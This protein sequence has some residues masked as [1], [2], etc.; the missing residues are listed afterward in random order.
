MS[1]TNNPFTTSPSGPALVP[2]SVHDWKGT[3]GFSY[4]EMMRSRTG[5]GT[6]AYSQQERFLVSLIQAEQRRLGR[7]LEVLEFG[8]GFGHHASYLAGLE[9]VRYHGYDMSEAMV[10]PL[11]QSPPVG[12]RPL[13]ERL[14][15]G[16]SPLSV[17]GSRRFDLVFTASVLIHNPIEAIPGLLDTLGQLTRPEGLVCLVENPLVPFGVWEDTWQQGCWLHAY[18]DAMPHGWD[19]HHG[20]GFT[21]THD[22]YVLKRN[23]GEQ[24]RYFEL[25]GPEQARDE[26]QPLTLEAL[27]ARAMPRLKAWANRAAHAL[28]HAAI[29]DGGR[30]QELQERMQVESERYQRRQQ[31]FALAEELAGL[32]NRPVK[33]APVSEPEKAPVPHPG[34]LF[35]DALDTTW[36]HKVPSLSHVV[37][38][39]HQQWH[40]IRA[41]AGYS[42]GRKL[43]ITAERSLTSKELR[44]AV[45]FCANSVSPVVI[46]HSFSAVAHEFIVA[47]RKLLGRKVRILCVWHGST[48]QFHYDY[49]FETFAHVMELCERGLVDSVGCVKPDMHLVSG[50]IYPKTLLNLPPRVE[51]RQRRALSG[52]SH[53]ALIPTPNDWRKNFYTNL[54]A[55]MASQHI[56]QVY[57]TARFISP[58]GLQPSKPVHHLQRPGRGEL[59]EAIRNVDVVLNASLSEC[60]PMTALESLALRV[61]CITGPLG[62]GALD[63]HPYQ[64]LTQLARVDL[65]GAVRDAMDGVLE[66]RRRSPEKMMEMMD[67][68]ESALRSEAIRHYEEFIHS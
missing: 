2:G 8:C 58:Q 39:F 51:A 45:E 61:P 38:V 24:R 19:L 13:P 34:V 68:Y 17:L 53:A 46:V 41:A 52:P 63:E 11:R 56:R 57:V 29:S 48:A 26:G 60:Q 10:R 12:M 44:Q 30:T 23:G 18:A 40:G 3:D 65:V 1:E 37:H 9:D 33:T 28:Q 31:L 5:Q 50:R 35:D 7:P 16:D 6:T 66:L 67:S 59:F 4:Q 27:Q 55:C 15:V 47:L 62:L 21:D 22:I 64:R 14:F 36:A 43:A 25:K 54:Y 20:T 42:P 49:E 32:R